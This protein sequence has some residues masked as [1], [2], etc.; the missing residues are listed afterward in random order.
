VWVWVFRYIGTLDRRVFCKLCDIGRRVLSQRWPSRVSS[1]VFVYMFLFKH[2]A[3]EPTVR[4][5][6]RLCTPG[7]GAPFCSALWL[8]ASCA[9]FCSARPP[10]TK[11][12]GARE[13]AHRWSASRGPARARAP[14]CRQRWRRCTGPGRAAPRPCAR[15]PG[16]GDYGSRVSRMVQ[17]HERA[18]R[19]QW[20]Q[21][22]PASARRCGCT[23]RTGSLAP[24]E[25][26]S[27]L[28]LGA[29]HLSPVR[30]G[31]DAALCVLQCVV[32]SGGAESRLRA[33]AAARRSG[34][35]G[36]WD[37]THLRRPQ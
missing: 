24:R 4:E 33:S 22:R 10:L 8:R 3:S 28:G 12:E 26:R 23:A 14:P 18:L 30:L 1:A 13:K 5:A 34:L 7:P 9:Q 27:R 29:L 32:V 19:S 25:R 17:R 15:S 37:G 11:A 35:L 20:L 21:C 36:G 16:E 6:R 2:S 31:A